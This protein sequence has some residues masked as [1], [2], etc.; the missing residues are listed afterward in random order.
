[1]LIDRIIVG[2]MFTN[3]YV[4]STG[5]KE[6]ILIDPGAA[7]QTIL[8]RLESMN[9]TPQAI[10]FTHGHLDHVS[11]TMGI[12]A[13]YRERDHTIPV[14]IH[15]DD[16]VFLGTGGI[17]KN[18][19]L[20]GSFG[21]QGLNAFNTFRKEVPEA[22]FFLSEGDTITDT[23]LQVFHTP[24]HSPGSVCLYSEGRQALFTGDSLFFNSIGRT[25]LPG[26]DS[27][28]LRDTITGRL[29]ELPPET[30]IFPGHG[31]VSSIERE[32]KSNPMLSDG[33]TI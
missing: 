1:M 22:D 20:F 5:K 33:A 32:I 21:D 6:C 8:Q 29:F 11:A 25:D 15:D 4:V 28:L 3:A 26:A 18:E 16:R 7:S 27:A 23:D 19:E 24:G 10:I 13:Y 30:R 12:I 9:L 17:A 2:N 31:P 14:G